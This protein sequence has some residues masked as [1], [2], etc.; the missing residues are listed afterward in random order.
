[1]LL[2]LLPWRWIGLATALALCG[3]IYA[4]IRHVGRLE[5]QLDAATAIANANAEIA[6]Q[7]R[8]FRRR[9]DQAASAAAIQAENTRRKYLEQRREVTHARAEDDGPL[10]PVLRHAL[11]GLPEL[12]TSAAIDRGAT[13]RAT[14]SPGLS[15]RA[16]ASRP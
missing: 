11:D 4:Q 14:L 6:D 1:M 15:G 10:A 16:E 13:R 9:A 3:V 8:A 7:E 5:S 12:E 2:S